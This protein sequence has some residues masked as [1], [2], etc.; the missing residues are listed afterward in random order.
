LPQTIERAMRA[1]GVREGQLE[2]EITESALMQDPES[3]MRTISFLHGTGV[4]FALDDFG[5]GYSSLA[6]LKNLQVQAIK[7][8]QSF[9]RDMVTDQRDAS[10]VRAAI[11]L[12]HNF[13]LS[14]VAEGVESEL[15]GDLLTS[16]DCD[17]AQG[18]H[19]ARPMPSAEF[20]E[21]YRER[22]QPN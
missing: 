22:Q 12:G 5:T 1:S 17:H 18:F 15:I 7:I 14:I 20:V 3:A 11:E 8:D 6:Y 13:N 4:A 9:V 16:L 21:W 10:I 19:F 2:F